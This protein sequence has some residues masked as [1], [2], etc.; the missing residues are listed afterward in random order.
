MS[1]TPVVDASPSCS[2]PPNVLVRPFASTTALPCRLRKVSVPDIRKQKLGYAHD[3][4]M[5]TSAEATSAVPWSVAC[6][7]SVTKGPQFGG[8]L[9]R[10]PPRSVIPSDRRNMIGLRGGNGTAV[11]SIENAPRPSWPD[12]A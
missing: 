6:M 10:Q 3:P 8:L 9:A 12:D 11:A 7:H 4:A 5:Y 1:T 2:M